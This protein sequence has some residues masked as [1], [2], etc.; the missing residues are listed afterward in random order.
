MVDRVDEITF[1]FPNRLERCYSLL[2][3]GRTVNNS[4]IEYYVQTWSYVCFFNMF[5]SVC[6]YGCIVRRPSPGVYIHVRTFQR[7][8]KGIY[9]K[10]KEF[11]CSLISP[12]IDLWISIFRRISPSRFLFIYLSWQVSSCELAF[13]YSL[14]IL[15]KS[16]FRLS[17]LR[18][19]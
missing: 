4:L 3:V 15:F 1:C 7:N 2:A 13:N 12:L 14:M 10:Q 6:I 11:F 5:R 9:F 16:D 18:G 8:E 17:A 19:R